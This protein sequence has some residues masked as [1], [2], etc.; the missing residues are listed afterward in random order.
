MVSV[1][2]IALSA[3]MGACLGGGGVVM[4]SMMQVGRM[5]PRSQVGA[6][7]GFMGFMLGIGSIVRTH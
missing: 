2:R 1:S 7:A 4:H 6:A 3:A 5:P